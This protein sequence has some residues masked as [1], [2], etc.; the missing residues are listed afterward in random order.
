[1]DED[2]KT[3]FALV[4]IALYWLVR[5]QTLITARRRQLQNGLGISKVYPCKKKGGGLQVKIC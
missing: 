4:G 3:V 5:D 1:M 2:S